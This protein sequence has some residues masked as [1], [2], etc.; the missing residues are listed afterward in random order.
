MKGLI[1]RGPYTAKAAREAGLIDRIAYAEQ[2]EEVLKQELKVDSVKV[3]RNYAQTKSDDIDLSNPFNILKLLSPG[4]T[5]GSK[6]PK[7]AVIYAVGEIVS[8]KGGSTLMGGD[9]VGS[10][11]MIEAIRQAEQDPTVKA[12]VLR[13]DSP[14]GSALASDLIWGELRRSNEAT[15]C[16]HGRR[17]GQ[18]RL[19][20]QHGGAKIYAEPG[21]LT[22][23]I[24]VVGGKMVLRGLQDKVGIK[25]EFIT[26]GANAGIM[27]ME[28]GF[29][30]TERKVIT[31]LMHD[32]YELF[33]EK[34]LQG[35]KRAGR[36]MTR[37]DLDKL[38]AGRVWTGRQ[39]KAAGLVDELGTL[40]DAIAAAKQLAGVSKDEEMELLVLPKPRG[41][42]EALL[43]R[44]A[45]AMTPA[46]GA[47]SIPLLGQVPELAAKLRGMEGLLRLRGEPIWAIMPHQVRI[48]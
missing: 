33:L 22:G 2:F 45:D 28:T 27:S 31:A 26:R 3:S 5:T 8:G 21:T 42:L 30:E 18:R 14:G 20:P 11:T 6:K 38:A 15:D 44:K 39:A 46:L 47:L 29:T 48:R 24:G 37:A 16:Q 43:D 9:M 34:A 17:G 23:S 32:T 35:R 7:I 13:V 10:T 25:T 36:K 1:D 12:I 19:L 41:F 4:K 40:A